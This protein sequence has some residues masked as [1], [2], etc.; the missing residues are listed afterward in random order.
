MLRE[1]AV[2][3]RRARQEETERLRNVVRELEV[4]R[5]GLAELIAELRGGDAPLLH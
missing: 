4:F 5:A 2:A 1:F 3:L